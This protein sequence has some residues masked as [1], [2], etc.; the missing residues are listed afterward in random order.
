MA[1]LQQK[2]DELMPQG[3]AYDFKG[4]SRQF[5]KE[6]N[7]LAVTFAFALLLIYLVLAAQFESFRDPFIIL[8]GLPATVFGAL[9]VLFILGEVNGMMQN[10]PP[11]NLGSGTINIYTQIGLVTLIGLIAKHG[12]LMVEFAN[13]LQETQGLRQERGHQGSGRG[14]PAPDPDDHGRHGDRRRSAADR[15]WRRRQEPLRHRRGHRRRHDDRHDVHAVHHACD[16]FLRRARPAATC[17][18]MRMRSAGRA[19]HRMSRCAEARQ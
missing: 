10:N 19:L 8:I 18:T 11:V 14:A 5:V 12:I 6:G 2:A 17:M 7:T 9:F 1:F 16:L 15:R 3:M 4:E 13:K